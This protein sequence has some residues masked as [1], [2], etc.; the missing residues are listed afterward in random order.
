ANKDGSHIPAYLIADA[1]AL[2]KYGL[3]MVRPGGKGL[4]PFLDDGYLVSGETLAELAAKLGIDA[5]G[6]TDSVARMNRFAQSGVDEDFHR[7][8]TVYE[9]VNGDATHGPNPTLGA[10]SQGP[11]FAVR[12]E[13]GDIGSATGLEGDT[14]AR[15]LGTAGKPIEG[16]YACGNDLQSIMGGVYPGPGITVGPGIV[17]GYIAARHAAGRARGDAAV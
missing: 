5:A 17:F 15:V 1:A 13:P 7:G 2:T 14:D 10:L 16:L 9:R 8:E 11:F 12:L 3:G 4:K 6:L